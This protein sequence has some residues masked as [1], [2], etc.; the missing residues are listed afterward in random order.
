MTNVFYTFISDDQL[1]Y[2]FY[3]HLSQ[4]PES[5]QIRIKR[6]KFPIDA[7][8][9]LYGKV[10]LMKG[11]SRMGISE[12]CLDEMVFTKF[13]RPYFN[14]DLDFNISHSG[15]CIMVA[16]TDN[17]RLGVDIEQLRELDISCFQDYFNR[18]EWSKISTAQNRFKRFFETWTQKEALVKA[19]GRGLSFPLQEVFIE[20]NKG[21]IGDHIWYLT[22]VILDEKYI[23]HLATSKKSLQCDISVEMIEVDKH[24]QSE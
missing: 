12:L 18:E 24:I 17:G 1:S 2:H 22:P 11:L 4:L 15:N 6:F 5:E 9:C 3:F 13:G 19:D 14:R 10:L 16:I 23:A 8:L 20:N 7:K 21:K